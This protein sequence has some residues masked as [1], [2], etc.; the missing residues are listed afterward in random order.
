MYAIV[1]DLD[2]NCLNE[3][4]PQEKYNNAYRDVRAFLESKGF[5]WMQ[6]STYFGDDSIDAVRCVLVA[7]QLAKAYP[8]FA[9]CVKDIRMLRIEENNNLMPAITP[10]SF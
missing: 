8:W 1:F 7:Q 5:R 2:T 4:Y 3:N 10:L 6:G 9:T